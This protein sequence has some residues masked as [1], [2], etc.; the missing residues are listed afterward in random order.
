MQ[1]K[2]KAKYLYNK[3]HDV[4]SIIVMMT[5]LASADEQRYHKEATAPD[6]TEKANMFSMGMDSLQNI[7]SNQWNTL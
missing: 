1:R 6:E 2:I 5:Y 3:V 4:E 7:V